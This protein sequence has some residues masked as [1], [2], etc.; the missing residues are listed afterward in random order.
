MG[1]KIFSMRWLNDGSVKL[2]KNAPQLLQ[3]LVG[4]GYFK[5]DPLLKRKHRALPRGFIPANQNAPNGNGVERDQVWESLDPRD[6]LEGQP[7]QVRVVV[8]GI[9]KV[10]V[11]NLRNGKRTT[12]DYKRFTGKTR[13]GF[14]LVA[15]IAPPLFT[16]AEA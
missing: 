7:R 4:D 5:Q 2:S 10:L 6:K 15:P 11:E 13:K 8:L 16:Q 3:K 9:D 1:R 12:V 14:K